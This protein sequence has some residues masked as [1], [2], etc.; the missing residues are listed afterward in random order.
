[1]P[2][3]W[4]APESG[5]KAAFLFRLKAFG[6]ALGRNASFGRQRFIMSI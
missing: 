1:M 6:V 2:A 5:V 4:A 3:D